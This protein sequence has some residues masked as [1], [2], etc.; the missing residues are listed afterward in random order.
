MDEERP[1]MTTRRTT[2]LAWGAALVALAVVAALAVFLHRHVGLALSALAG[3]NP[4]WLLLAVV[5]FAT[6]FLATVGAW[7]AAFAAAGA[8]I[9]PH[10]AAARLGV[11]ALVNAVAP[12]KLGDAVKV[13]LCSRALEGPRPL[14]TGG[15]VYAALAAARSLALAALV[16]AASLAG[17]LPLWPVALLC[18]VAAGLVLVARSSERWRSHPRLTQLLEGMSSLAR[19]PRTALTIVGWSLVEQLTK[20]LAA[21]AVARAFALPHPVLAALLILP[22]LEL[23]GVFPLTP[24][25]FGIGSG[26][27]AVALSSQGIGMTQALAVGLAIQTLETAVS[28]TAGSVGALYLTRL[29]MTVRRYALRVA[30]LGGSAAFAAGVGLALVSVT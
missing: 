4:H 24:G 23:T 7:H 27:V 28:L 18:C 2:I 12:A 22:A 21:V 8:R 16:V 3:G 6:A 20:L 17:A 5:G 26:A 15:G 30:M 14:W 10:E 29:N 11:G 25:S 9:A 13:A 19:S 1:A